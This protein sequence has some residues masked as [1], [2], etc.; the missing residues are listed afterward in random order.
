M[1]SGR[2]QVVF[3]ERD[4]KIEMARANHKKQNCVIPEVASVN[5]IVASKV[6][7]EKTL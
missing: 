2:G 4:R 7:G 1:F 5:Q 3:T 6:R